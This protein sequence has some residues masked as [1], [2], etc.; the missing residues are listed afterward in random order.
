[1]FAWNEL[2]SSHESV[3]DLVFFNIFNFKVFNLIVKNLGG[4]IFFPAK[5]M[6]AQV[7]SALLPLSFLFRCSVSIQLSHLACFLAGTFFKTKSRQSE[8]S[9]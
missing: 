7:L 6:S 9:G 4:L 3:Y 5:R 8:N 1:M 2:L